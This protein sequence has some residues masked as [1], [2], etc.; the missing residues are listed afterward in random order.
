MTARRTQ[1]ATGYQEALGDISDALAVGGIDGVKKWLL[2]NLRRHC[3]HGHGAMEVPV[4][5]QWYCPKCGD[6]FPRAEAL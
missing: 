4:A 1:Y 5:D 2:D 3:P 6:E